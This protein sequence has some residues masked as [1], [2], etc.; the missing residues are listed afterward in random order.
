MH[1]RRAAS[2]PA[3]GRLGGFFL[4]LGSS[5]VSRTEEPGSAYRGRTSVVWPPGDHKM[6][7]ALVCTRSQRWKTRAGNAGITS[8]NIGRD[9]SFV[10]DLNRN[11]VL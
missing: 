2:A 4:P 9:K 1:E 11:K 10:D 5:R 6:V 7:M 8:S 3:L